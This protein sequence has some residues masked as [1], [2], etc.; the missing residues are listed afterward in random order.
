MD[1]N[2]EETF[3]KWQQRIS[4]YG[5]VN[6]SQVLDAAWF[7]IPQHRERTFMISIRID[8]ENIIPKFSFPKV[9]IKGELDDYIATTVGY[10]YYLP[11]AKCDILL[12]L[13]RS[14]VGDTIKTSTSTKSKTSDIIY[15]GNMKEQYVTPVCRENEIPTLTAQGAHG[16]PMAMFSTGEHPCPGVI[17]IWTKKKQR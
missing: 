16:M 10:K 5:Y 9:F 14:S 7:G 12:K 1:M 4:K 2:N 13:L 3:L 6:Y 15:E 8:N 11:Q 17:E